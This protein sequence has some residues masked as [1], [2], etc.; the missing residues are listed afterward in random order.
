ML[1]R[2]G[3]YIGTEFQ[4]SDRTNQHGTGEDLDW[5]TANVDA[6][7]GTEPWV[8]YDALIE[9]RSDM[10]VWAAKDL[11]F[12]RTLGLVLGRMAAIEP[13]R[14]VLVV[15]CRRK[16]EDCID[17]FMR[18][19]L[20]GRRRA[21][22]WY[23]AASLN[24][25]ARLLEF[26]GGPLQRLDLHWED[27]QRDPY[28]TARQLAA[29]VR[30]N[31][32]HAKMQWAADHIKPREERG[33][34]FGSVAIG[35]RIASHPAVPFFVSWTKLLTGGTR[36]GD[37]VLMPRAHGPAHQSATRIARDFLRSNRDT[38][39]MVDD[40]MDFPGHQLEVMR[41]SATNQDFDVV[42]AFATHRA[43][44]PKPVMLHWQ[45][46]A[47]NEATGAYSFVLPTEQQGTMQ[48]DAVGLAFTLIRRSVLAAMLGDQDIELWFPFE[49]GAGWESDDIPWSARCREMGFRMGIDTDHPIG[50][51]GCHSYGWN[52]YLEWQAKLT[53]VERASLQGRPPDPASLDLDG[54]ELARVLAVALG[55]QPPRGGD[56]ELARRMLQQITGAGTEQPM[57]P[58]DV[59]ALHVLAGASGTQHGGGGAFPPGVYRDET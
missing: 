34:G 18:A 37:T 51:I 31:P 6:L 14:E 43:H 24:V 11:A 30:I 50:H 44:P 46:P 57:G 53:E 25:A 2:L 22:A 49:Y 7:K 17:S 8:A 39:L 52:D 59:G 41:E 20:V 12:A 27:T 13:D 48:T 33:S 26:G 5:M 45:G 21:T 47:A 58:G 35:V 10:P 54:A 40:D 9:Q 1:E 38:L 32:P 23:E 16:R 19:Y 55:E 4:A 15:V 28:R 36:N 3:V 42:M 29:F 56:R